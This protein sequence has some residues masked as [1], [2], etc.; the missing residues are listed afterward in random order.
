MS[1]GKF[2]SMTLA[3]EVKG[4]MKHVAN[5]SQ[6]AGSGVSA[7]DIRAQVIAQVLG[8]VWPVEIAREREW[9]KP[10]RPASRLFKRSDLD[11]GTRGRGLS[12]SSPR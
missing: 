7:A 4:D 11:F 12:V 10:Q 1:W 6:C 3:L 9:I 2:E 8:L 5:D